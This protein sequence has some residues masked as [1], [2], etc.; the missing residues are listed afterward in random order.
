LLIAS[1]AVFWYFAATLLGAEIA[2]LREG[3]IQ[4]DKGLE[5]ES[6]GILQ[7][8]WGTDC[9]WHDHVRGL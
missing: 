6:N 3:R 8:V 1:P 9:R 4:N 5:G 7:S 2:R